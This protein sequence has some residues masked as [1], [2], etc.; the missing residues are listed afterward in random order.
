MNSVRMPWVSEVPHPETYVG[1]PQPW[2]AGLKISYPEQDLQQKAPAAVV[3]GSQ[4]PWK[5][6]RGREASPFNWKGRAGVCFPHL[7]GHLG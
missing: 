5:W 6:P 4:G 7:D 2:G 1:L 3:R